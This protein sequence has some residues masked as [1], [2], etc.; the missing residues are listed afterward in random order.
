MSACATTEPGRRRGATCG[1]ASCCSGTAHLRASHRELPM[2]RSFRRL[3]SAALILA[4]IAAYAAKPAVPA[5]TVGAAG[6]KQLQFDVQPVAGASY[7]ELWFRANGGA[8]W[9][10]RAT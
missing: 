1:R 3:A 5:V 4:P 9:V 10:K 6:M 2:Y 8:S 7:Y